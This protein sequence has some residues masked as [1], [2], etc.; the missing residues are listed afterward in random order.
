MLYSKQYVLRLKSMV[1]IVPIDCCFVH[2]RISRRLVL[3]AQSISFLISPLSMTIYLNASNMYT[4]KEIVK[5]T[6]FTSVKNTYDFFSKEYSKLQ[7]I[8]ANWHKR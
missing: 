8:T 6:L 3:L 5:K 2:T 7:N 1:D 4:T